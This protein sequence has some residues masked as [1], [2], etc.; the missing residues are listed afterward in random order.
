M[1]ISSSPA[2]IQTR[3]AA[4]ALGD[5]RPRLCSSIDFYLDQRAV[6]KFD[7]KLSTQRRC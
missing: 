6:R 2:S 5:K 1:Q 7:F 4:T 3:K